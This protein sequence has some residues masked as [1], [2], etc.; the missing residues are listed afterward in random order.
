MT[1]D[2]WNDVTPGAFGV[3]TVDSV[4]YLSGEFDL[5]GI[6]LFNEAAARLAKV[7]RLIVDLTELE[8]MDS[9]GLRA[10]MNLDLRTRAEGA[11]LTLRGPKPEVSR[12]LRMC[13]FYERLEITNG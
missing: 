7:D 9:S 3:R 13:G 10:L 11:R 2:P 5:S 4:L 6:S 12:L 1:N 8:F